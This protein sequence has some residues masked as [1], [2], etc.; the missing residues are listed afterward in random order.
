MG[1]CGMIYRQLATTIS[2]LVVTKARYSILRVL[3]FLIHRM[4]GV[5][6]SK[7]LIYCP[8]LHVALGYADCDAPAGE[9]IGCVSREASGVVVIQLLVVRYSGYLALAGWISLA[10]LPRT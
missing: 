6:F 5:R 1:V 4:Y 8:L 3:Y 2:Q 9:I 7:D 10:C